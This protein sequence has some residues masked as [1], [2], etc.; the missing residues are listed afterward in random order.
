MDH[1]DKADFVPVD[2]S[3]FSPAQ[4]SKVQDFV[5]QLGSQVFT[6]G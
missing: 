4:A 1:I 6:V 5:D 2:I 3:G